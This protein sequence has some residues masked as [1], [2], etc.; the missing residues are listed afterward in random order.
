MPYLNPSTTGQETVLKRA[1]NNLIDLILKADWLCNTIYVSVIWHQCCCFDCLSLAEL[2]L[3]IAAKRAIKHDDRLKSI[4]PRDI[5][6]GVV[7]LGWEWM[8]KLRRWI[9]RRWK[10]LVWT[11]TSK[12]FKTNE[13]Y[14]SSDWSVI[15]AC[16]FR[17]PQSSKP[18]WWCVYYIVEI[19]WISLRDCRFT[20]VLLE[21][22]GLSKQINDDDDGV[23]FEFMESQG[24]LRTVLLE[25]HVEPRRTRQDMNRGLWRRPAE[26]VLI[27]LT[28]DDNDDS[29]IYLMIRSISTTFPKPTTM[30]LR[31][32]IQISSPVLLVTYICQDGSEY[33]CWPKVYDDRIRPKG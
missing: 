14:L 29:S 15:K 3:P 17:D 11:R 20:L 19:L 8:G 2:H 6:F 24:I 21:T 33:R 27:D 22:C 26:R 31:G 23:S 16:A 7:L 5:V 10:E 32:S 4:L 12:I 30:P 18:H 25:N 13:A 1:W 28:L 9:K